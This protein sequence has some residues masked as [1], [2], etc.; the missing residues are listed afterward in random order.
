MCYD[1]KML[2]AIA[3][4]NGYDWDE[5]V[6]ISRVCGDLLQHGI[7]RSPAT[8]RSWFRG[9]TEPSPSILAVLAKMFS[10]HPGD[11]FGGV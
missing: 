3:R 7:S 5:H 2:R 9:E 6:W 10:V 8:V 1:H 11:F 4:A